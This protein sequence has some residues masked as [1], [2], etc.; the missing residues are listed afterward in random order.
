MHSGVFL[1][2]VLHDALKQRCNYQHVVNNIQIRLKIRFHAISASRFVEKNTIK[3]ADT[4]NEASRVVE[5][6]IK[7]CTIYSAENVF[8]L[9]N[10]VVL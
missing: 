5:T 4:C 10:T 1:I 7:E 8:Q 3:G 2:Y 9:Q 6:M